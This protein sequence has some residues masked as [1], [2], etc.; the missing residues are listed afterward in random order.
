MLRETEKGQTRRKGAGSPAMVV[1]Q[2]SFRRSPLPPHALRAALAALLISSTV[3]AGVELQAHEDVLPWYKQEAIEWE[4]HPTR[5]RQPVEAWESAFEGLGDF[6]FLQQYAEADPA[7][8]SSENTQ[9]VAPKRLECSCSFQKVNTLAEPKSGYHVGTL[10]SSTKSAPSRDLSPQAAPKAGAFVEETTASQDTAKARE[11]Q[12]QQQ[13]QQQQ[14]RFAEQPAAAA[15]PGIRGGAAT[16]NREARRRENARQFV[17]RFASSDDA[18]ERSPSEHRHS[19]RAA[20]EWVD[21]PYPVDDFVEEEDREGGGD[22]GGSS[23]RRRH[24]YGAARARRHQRRSFDE[25]DEEGAPFDDERRE[26]APRL[27]RRRSSRRRYGDDEREDYEEDR[28]DALMEMQQR[29]PVEER[30]RQG[31]GEGEDEEEQQREDDD[32]RLHRR[33]H[34]RTHHQ[35][36]RRRLHNDPYAHESEW[37]EGEFRHYDG[38]EPRR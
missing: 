32:R 5:G 7:E 30:Q 31:G 1:Q 20:R 19:R 10:D 9:R 28:P 33:A 27:H 13:Q 6:E 2:A 14:A 35:H 25:D 15:G 37:E 29:Y 16:N 22:E 21:R 18:P 23:G 24:Y 4:V 17:E 11:S 3:G 12:A 8:S 38:F 26:R 34:R 36:R